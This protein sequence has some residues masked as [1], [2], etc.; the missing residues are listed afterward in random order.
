MSFNYN[1]SSDSIQDILSDVNSSSAG[2]T[3]AYDTLNNQFTVT[4]NTTGNVGIS[5]QDGTGSNF[6][7]A[8]GL[9]N[10]TQTAG[11]NLLETLNGSNAN[12]P[13]QSESNTITSASSGINGLSVTA[14]QT[15][16]VTMTVT[17]AD[18]SQ[19]STAI[20]QFVTD[21]NTVQSY[22]ANQQAV[23]TAS[24]GTVTA[25]TLTG[26]GNRQSAR[27]RFA[28][29]RGAGP[30]SGFSGSGVNLLSDLGIETNGQTN[31][32]SLSDTST[33][34]SALQSN[35][36]AVQQFFTSRQWLGAHR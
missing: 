14:T 25:G 21:Y 29:E 9:L 36:A 8:T 15:G 11:Q 4:N 31:T 5:L 13:L 12:T 35:L 23:S 10:G 22:I 26:D 34:D 18:T 20:Q 1:A 33:L 2:V 24:D 19:I 30:V 17:A 6:L 28:V 16:S 32:L 27:V 7:A 3:V